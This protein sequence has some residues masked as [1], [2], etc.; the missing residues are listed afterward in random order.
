MDSAH[1][2]RDGHARAAIHHRPHGAGIHG[3]VLSGEVKFDTA[4]LPRSQFNVGVEVTRLISKKSKTPH[5]VSY[6]FPRR[7]PSSRQGQPEISPAHRAGFIATNLIRPGGMVEIHP[8][9]SIVLSA[10]AARQSAAT[11]RRRQDVTFLHVHRGRCPR[12]ISIHRSATA[13]QHSTPSIS[14][15]ALPCPARNLS[16]V[17]T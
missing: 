1:P 12:L 15:L 17:L 9:F 8:S 16:A 11:A 3:E 10:C 5:V 2:P 7:V 14:F 4:A 13:K 6:D